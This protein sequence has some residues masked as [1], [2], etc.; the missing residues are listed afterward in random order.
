[1]R[2]SVS[3]VPY[4]SVP[5]SAKIRCW[6]RPPDTRFL[7]N[8]DRRPCNCVACRKYVI[9]HPIARPRSICGAKTVGRSAPIGTRSEL[10]VP[11]AGACRIAPLWAPAVARGCS[12][13]PRSP[14]R[15]RPGT[16]FRV[17][18]DP[19]WGRFGP[20]T[21]KMFGVVRTFWAP[22]WARHGPGRPPARDR[23]GGTDPTKKIFLAL[24][25]ARVNI[26]DCEIQKVSHTNKVQKLLLF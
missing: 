13:T 18:S 20:E 4:S 1:M 7:Q 12:W 15:S 25:R 19:F 22:T 24:F 8:I 9:E 17:V 26:L 5:A 10:G 2:F 14:D 16:S 21:E 11:A 3:H 6:V 23:P